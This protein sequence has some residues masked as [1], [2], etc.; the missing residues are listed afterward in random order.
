M[1]HVIGM[2]LALDCTSIAH[3]GAELHELAHKLRTTG[4]EPGTQCTDV[5][6][7]AAEFNAGRHIMA[8]TVGIANFKAGSGAAL[9]GFSAFE[10]GICVIV[11]HHFHTHYYAFRRPTVV[12]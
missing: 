8:F 9:A 3:V 11:L 7:V 12:F 1:D 10:A 5:G 4:L 6:A 2:F